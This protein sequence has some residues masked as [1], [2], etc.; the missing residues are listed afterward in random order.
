VIDALGTMAFGGAGTPP[1]SIV[2]RLDEK[3]AGELVG[4]A[5][6]NGVN[7]IHLR[8]H[9]PEGHVKRL[10]DAGGVA[11][12]STLQRNVPRLDRVNKS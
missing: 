3:T 5:L 9:P 2:G 4:L 12:H 11:S 10:L 1:W 6:D 8:P 7:L